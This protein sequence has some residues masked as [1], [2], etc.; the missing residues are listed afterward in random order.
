MAAD[1]YGNYWEFPGGRKNAEESFAAC[2]AREVAEEIG[3]KIEVKKKLTEIKKRFSDKII[4]LNFF[5]CSYASG[6]PKP[7]E[8]QAVRWAGL[9]ELT[10]IK[11]PPANHVVIKKLTELYGR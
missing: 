4:W 3:V 10:E 5:L 9:E 8:C 6:E 1:T 2:V 7:I 11:F